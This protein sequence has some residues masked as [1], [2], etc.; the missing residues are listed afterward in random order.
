MKGT[1]RD[2]T[3]DTGA[4]SETFAILKTITSLFGAEATGITVA[5]KAGWAGGGLLR[6]FG[7]STPSRFI[8][9]PILMCR[10]L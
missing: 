3:K 4:V 10:L 5:T 9:I 2:I 7:I 6:E 8:P 1:M